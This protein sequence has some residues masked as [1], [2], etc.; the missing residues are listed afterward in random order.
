MTKVNV[1]IK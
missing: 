1:Q